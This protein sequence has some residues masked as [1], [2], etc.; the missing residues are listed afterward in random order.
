MK[1]RA[2]EA[3]DSLIE[4][5]PDFFQEESESALRQKVEWIT[6]H[7]GVDVS[8]LAHLL[9]TEESQLTDWL[10]FG[11]AISPQHQDEL[12]DL[13]RAVLHLLSFQNFDVARVRQ[14]L[15]RETGPVPTM[16]PNAVPWA[17]SSMRTYLETKG[18]KAVA[19]LTD[20][21]MSLRFRDPYTPR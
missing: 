3:A 19:E 15:E 8:F 7:L 13:W 17:G 1:A 11:G 4:A 18:S 14:M 10:R 16:P 20:W 9:R 12:S 2:V 21:V 5:V 6:D